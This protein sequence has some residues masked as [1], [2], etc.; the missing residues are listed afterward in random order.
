MRHV[1][2]YVLLCLGLTPGTP[3][4][5]TISGQASVMDGDTLEIHG[6]RIRLHGIDAPESP[7]HCYLPDGKT[8]RCGQ[9]AALQLQDFI[10]NQMVACERKGQDRYGRMVAVCFAGGE[11]LGAW[12]VEHGWALAYARYST[13]YVKQQRQAEAV[14]AGMWQSRFQKPWAW[15]LTCKENTG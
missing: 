7:Q 12:L 13:A 4:A 1:F 9:T 8:W 10:G 3:Q 2:M 14:Q 11:D 6:Q 15:R 5:S